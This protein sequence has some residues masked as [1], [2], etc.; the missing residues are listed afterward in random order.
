MQHFIFLNNFRPPKGKAKPDA[1]DIF[2]P[3]E[4]YY[5]MESAL[6]R[7]VSNNL[8]PKECSGEKIFVKIRAKFNN[9]KN[10]RKK[11]V[12]DKT[13]Y[14]FSKTFFF[15]K[16]LKRFFFYSLRNLQEIK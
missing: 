11:V 8:I 10:H 13:F 9:A 7:L 1:N 6:L 4:L 15:L 2:I 16:I 12:P 3:T 14:I 5:F